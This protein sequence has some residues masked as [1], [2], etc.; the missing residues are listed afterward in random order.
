M[1]TT[2]RLFI[3]S[4]NF[5]AGYGEQ[6]DF[7]FPHLAR[8]N[9][10]TIELDGEISVCGCPRY[11]RAL[12][13]PGG[14]WHVSTTHAD[15]LSCFVKPLTEAL[16]R[17]Y[18]TAR[19]A[20]IFAEALL[21][22]ACTVE[23]LDEFEEGVNEFGAHGPFREVFDL[24]VK[25]RE[26]QEAHPIGARA[27]STITYTFK[28][29][30]DD[31]PEEHVYLHRACY[32]D[33]FVFGTAGD[34]SSIRLDHESSTHV[35]LVDGRWLVVSKMCFGKEECA[36]L[37][38]AVAEKY[39]K[40]ERAWL[41]LDKLY[42]TN[43]DGRSLALVAAAMKDLRGYIEALDEYYAMVAQLVVASR[44]LCNALR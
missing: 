12:R 30:C 39:N 11:V 6:H 32:D 2:D 10:S 8:A 29:V 25:M 1:L 4:V 27:S 9:G 14:T 38:S 33:S 20:E 18:D 43:V 42:R 16:A 17:Y 15:G 28:D 21:S 23:T 40:V 3:R 44:S 19:C 22:D 13:L 7:T 31:G 5:V 36:L 35:V 34:A 24:M 37:T 26:A 41:L